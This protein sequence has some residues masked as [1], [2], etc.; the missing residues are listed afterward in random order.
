MPPRPQNS[1]Y[2]LTATRG[3]ELCRAALLFAL[4]SGCRE[5]EVDA[6]PARVVEAFVDR[7][8]AVHGDPEKGLLA[9]ELLGKEA[10]ANLEERAARASAAA[11]RP[12][13]PGEMLAPSRLSLAFEPVEYRAENR[14]RWSRVTVL[15]ANPAVERVEVRCELE[16]EGW[17]VQLDLP[18]LPLI[19]RSR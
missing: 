19:E 1:H 4:V 16:A 9:L 3:A 12:V 17:R 2:R 14:G 6:D 10:R 11:G 18:P 5:Q 15:G 8:R 7:M 13:S